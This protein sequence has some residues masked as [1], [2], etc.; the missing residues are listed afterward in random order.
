MRG[1]RCWIPCHD[2][3]PSASSQTP[4]S[5]GFL[6]SVSAG[7][8][9][10]KLAAGWWPRCRKGTGG[11]ARCRS[12]ACSQV[13]PPFHQGGLARGTCRAADCL[14]GDASSPLAGHCSVDGHLEVGLQV[15]QCAQLL[16]VLCRGAFAQRTDDTAYHADDFGSLAGL[17]RPLTLPSHA[18]GPSPSSAQVF[19]SNYI[20]LSGHGKDT[21]P[22]NRAWSQAPTAP[23]GRRQ[24]S[25]ENV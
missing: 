1:C 5:G 12:G 25:C 23:E 21:L 9:W 6:L 7:A 17:P 10:A 14:P 20:S 13:R 11:L 24:G 4:L 15:D 16:G 3:R 18:E 2:H 19:T 22:R 8:I